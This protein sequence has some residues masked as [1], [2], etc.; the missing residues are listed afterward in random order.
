MANFKELRVWNVCGQNRNGQT[1][2]VIYK[3]MVI[4]FSGRKKSSGIERVRSLLDMRV[5]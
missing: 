2:T 3:N 1:K 5:F 4:M